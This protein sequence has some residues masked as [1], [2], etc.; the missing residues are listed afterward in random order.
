MQI[1]DNKIQ[2]SI[3]LFFLFNI[4]CTSLFDFDEDS[5][6]YDYYDFSEPV[7]TIKDSVN[8][9]YEKAKE[10]IVKP[11]KS[12]PLTINK[13]KPTAPKQSI[14]KSNGKKTQEIT[15]KITNKTEK[16]EPS[17]VEDETEKSEKKDVEKSKKKDNSPSFMDY[18]TVELALVLFAVFII[19]SIVC[20]S[21]FFYF[22][23]GY[24]ISRDQTQMADHHRSL[25]R[26]SIE[27]DNKDEKIRKT[28]R[29]G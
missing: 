29:Y 28:V 1:L 26:P 9:T 7:Q 2:I 14:D 21:I 22:Y 18:I 3:I 4:F 17:S 23:N 5:F 19:T 27:P 10:I 16:E 24:S 8:D 6:F 12:Q 15:N 11:N 13:N 20:I 25:T